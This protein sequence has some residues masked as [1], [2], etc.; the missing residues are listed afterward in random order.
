[1]AYVW[2]E[3]VYGVYRA[4]M[5][6]VRRVWHM[7][8]RCHSISHARCAAVDSGDGSEDRAHD[9]FVCVCMRA[10]VYVYVTTGTSGAK[11]HAEHS[12]PPS[13]DRC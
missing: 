3:G 13:S 4:C 11:H 9:S 12:I 6:Y 5:A 1:M 10:Y 7:Y 8:A 2:R